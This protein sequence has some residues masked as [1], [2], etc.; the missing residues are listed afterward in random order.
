ML[1]IRDL[2]VQ[3]QDKII[4]HQLNLTIPAGQVHAIM[5]PNGAGKSTLSAVLAGNPQFNV[6]SGSITFM[7]EDLLALAPHERALRGIFIAFQYPVTLPGVG[8][9]YLLKAALNAKRTFLGLPPVDAQECLNLARKH[10]K[11]L[12]MDESFLTRAVN[13]DFSGGEKKRNEMLQMLTLEPKLAVLDETDSGLDID[14]LKLVAT[15]VASMR[16][17]ERSFLIITHYPRILEYVTPDAVHV[18]K[19]GRLVKSGGKELAWELE[20]VGYGD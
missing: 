5:G 6:T 18:L 12:G 9:I 11:A 10:L 7:G 2:T 14:S 4:I 17:S 19:A 15:A 13:E 3:V 1:I 8:N 20:K 16:N